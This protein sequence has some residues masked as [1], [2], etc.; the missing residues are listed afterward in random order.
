MQATLGGI[1]EVHT[2]NVNN[3]VLLRGRQSDKFEKGWTEWARGRMC[4]FSLVQFWAIYFVEYR[5]SLSK[6]NKSVRSWKKK[7]WISL[8]ERRQFE[9]VSLEKSQN[10]WFEPDRQEFRN[11]KKYLVYSSVN[12]W[13]N[14]YIWQT[15]ANFT[16][17]L[18][19][20]S[21]CLSQPAVI[22][23]P[24]PPAWV[25]MFCISPG[26][27]WMSQIQLLGAG[28]GVAGQSPEWDN[29]QSAFPFRVL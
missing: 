24:G 4:L 14:N 19:C 7:I 9:S 26:G 2:F 13:D 21:L 25:P 5:G 29:L 27:V 18:L 28:V 8:L 3:Y 10:S 17:Y 16:C 6:Q 1:P 15:K 11:N 20:C 22:Q 12:F 23:H